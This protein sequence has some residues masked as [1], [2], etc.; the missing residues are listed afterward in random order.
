MRNGLRVKRSGPNVVGPSPLVCVVKWEDA[1]ST[2]M[3]ACITAPPPSLKELP[4]GR[5]SGSWCFFGLSIFLTRF[6]VELNLIA[7]WRGASSRESMGD[8]YLL[9]PPGYFIE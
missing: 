3:W 9:V 2:I 7:F 6:I 4:F 1:D 8:W 5:V